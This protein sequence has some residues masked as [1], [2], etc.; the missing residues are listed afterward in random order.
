VT[1][2]EAFVLLRAEA[3]TYPDGVQIWMKVMSGSFFLGLPV[4]LIN[5]RA[6]W[7]VAAAIL[8]AAALIAVK[9]LYPSL[10]RSEI[11]A[12]AHLTI[13]P[14]GLAGLWWGGVKATVTRTRP[15]MW[16]TVFALWA[17]WVSAIMVL[18]LVLDAR[19]LFLQGI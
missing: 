6:L 14:V 13:W 17:F 2:T 10:P 7:I 16:R 18:S 4:A 8:T 1:L 19:E 5:R 3:A 11:G 15:G 9:T 12:L